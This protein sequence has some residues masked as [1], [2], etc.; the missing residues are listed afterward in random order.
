VAG[1]DPVEVDARIRA[2]QQ[3]RLFLRQLA[4]RDDAFPDW[5]FEA[6]AGD[7]DRFVRP[8][9]ATGPVGPKPRMRFPFVQPTPPNLPGRGG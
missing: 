5:T 7:K 8:A 1:W 2:S 9:V 6:R 3:R 4:L